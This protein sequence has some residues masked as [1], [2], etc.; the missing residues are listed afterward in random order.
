[1]INHLQEVEIALALLNKTTRISKRLDN[2]LG[3]I[4]GIG[5]TE[6]LVLRVLSSIPSNSLRRIDIAESLGRTASGITRVLLPMEK[7]GL[8]SKEV[9]NRDAR[10]SLVK[11]TG[12]GKTIFEDASATVEQKCGNLFTTWNE[13]EVKMM[14]NLLAKI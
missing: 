13:D 6:Y 11:M 5:L 8:I 1:M 10:V 14:F 4:H 7:T 2:S 9:N 3:A 12:S